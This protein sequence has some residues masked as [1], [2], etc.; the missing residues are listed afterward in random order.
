MIHLKHEISTASQSNAFGDHID[1]TDI[2]K[3]LHRMETVKKCPQYVQ[4]HSLHWWRHCV[5]FLF[6]KKVWAKCMQKIKKMKRRR[7]RKKN[8]N[9]LITIA[10]FENLIINWCSRV[11]DRAL[12][13]M[14]GSSK[15]PWHSRHRHRCN[16]QRHRHS[17]GERWSDT[18]ADRWKKEN[19][20]SYQFTV[21]YSESHVRCS[22]Q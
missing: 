17:N 15:I 18:I 10:F 20:W 16:T 4:K 8:R 6:R 19:N 22:Q 5:C 13:H 7:R 9:L 12:T 3:S 1:D 2:N 21:V 11:R 14:R